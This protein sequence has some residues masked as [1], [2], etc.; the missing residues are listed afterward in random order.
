MLRDNRETV[1]IGSVVKL[2]EKDDI[3]IARDLIVRKTCKGRK[4][5]RVN[6]YKEDYPTYISTLR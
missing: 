3:R 6:F 1:G 2:Y 4:L 5:K